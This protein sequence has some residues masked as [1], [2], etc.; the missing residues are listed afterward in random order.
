MAAA[1]MFVATAAIAVHLVR[2]RTLSDV[3]GAS[4]FPAGSLRPSLL[5]SLAPRER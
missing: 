5:H 2:A 3:D 1:G 4:R